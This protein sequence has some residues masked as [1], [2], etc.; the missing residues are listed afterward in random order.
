MHAGFKQRGKL[1]LTLHP[2]TPASTPNP[3]LLRLISSTNLSPAFGAAVSG[4][5]VPAGLASP[6]AA[7]SALVPALC[8]RARRV[9]VCV[10]ACVC[11]CVLEGRGS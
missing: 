10:C 1:T 6:P 4:F 11:V 3:P 9:C 5:V 2:I 7:G 8:P